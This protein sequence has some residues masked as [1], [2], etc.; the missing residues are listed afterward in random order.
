MP[1]ILMLINYSW[2][3]LQGYMLSDLMPALDAFAAWYHEVYTHPDGALDFSRLDRTR[4]G[5]YRILRLYLDPGRS[6]A[7]LDAE[8]KVAAM[9]RAS[10]PSDLSIPLL[11]ICHQ[12][13]GLHRDVWI[14]AGMRYEEFGGGTEPIYGKD[15]L[16]G[17]ARSH[18]YRDGA[19]SVAD[20]WQGPPPYILNPHCTTRV[21]QYYACLRP[22]RR[23]YGQLYEAPLLE[24]D[25]M[26]PLRQL[27]AHLLR[28]AG[29]PVAAAP[30]EVPSGMNLA[31]CGCLTDLL[32]A[33]PNADVQSLY[34]TLR[35]FAEG[36]PLSHEAVS[37]FFYQFFHHWNN[38]NEP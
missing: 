11:M 32:E 4:D 19:A 10:M 31:D 7:V 1:E 29:Q 16:I 21:W 28:C 3:D 33:V 13:Q 26:P 37:G 34:Q 36:G 8:Q 2:S 15:G 6:S 5:K 24:A 35:S 12:R 27:A 17:P 30:E 14:Q 23:L 18:Y 25:A 20:N 38:R 22:L 9:I